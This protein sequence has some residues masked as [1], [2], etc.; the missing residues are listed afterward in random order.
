MSGSV[1]DACVRALERELGDRVNVDADHLERCAWDFGRMVYR[2]PA[3]VAAVG[4]VEELSASLRIA[5]E[6]GMPVATRGS[7]HSQSGQCLSQD[8]LVLDL[9]GLN[10]VAL[11]PDRGCA[12]LGG[13]A[14]WQEVCNATS[15]VGYMP[16]GLTMIVDT[17]VGGT[18][19][20]GGVGSESFR[21]G[22]QVD[23]VIELDVATLNENAGKVTRCSPQQNRELF[24]AVRAGVGQCGV[25]LA[26]RYPLRKAKK[27][28]R[29]NTL[30]YANARDLVADMQTLGA[31][32]S[33]DFMFGC[34]M[35]TEQ[36][37][38]Q[39]LLF[40]GQELD[41]ESDASAG[42]SLT[43]LK[44]VRQL[45]PQ[46]HIQWRS[47]GNPGHPF[48]RRFA[49]Q[50]GEV[51]HNPW[52]DYVCMPRAAGELLTEVTA[53]PA[54]AARG[55]V[56]GAVL[57]IAP[58]TNRAPLVM[59]SSSE[60]LVLL[61]LFPESSKPALPDA[62][63]RIA[64]HNTRASALGAKRYLSGFLNDWKAPEWSDHF[65][66]ALPWFRQMKSRFDPQGLLNSECMTW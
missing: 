63:A 8:G 27:S 46:T 2:R 61:G 64:Q 29:T 42:T 54:V 25:I 58:H 43:G 53:E 14:T 6:L 55:G 60:P 11:E 32:S 4:S 28:V 33:L 45:P 36:S 39:F 26:A 47:D 13:G 16:V 10:T 37:G 20:V 57:N 65:G 15:A 22:L 31:Q 30:I 34:L 23:Q 44:F 17:T 51:M 5:A 59:P 3:I 1:R 62:L 52:A 21:R 40:L 35:W 9:R 49:K 12:W 7:G 24:D 38:W 18:L 56:C 50:G 41:D 66:A 19:S 48:F